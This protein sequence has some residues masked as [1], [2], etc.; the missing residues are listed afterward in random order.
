MHLNHCGSFPRR[1][2]LADYSR[3]GFVDGRACRLPTVIVRAGEPNA[4]TTGCFS[5][6]V[7][8]PLAG[9]NVCVEQHYY[10]I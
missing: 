1:L 8:E 10:T 4:A 7:R 5:S 6:I 3:R 2:L 9:T